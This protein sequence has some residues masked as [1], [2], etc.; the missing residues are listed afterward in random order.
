MH[1]GR[2]PQYID[3]NYGQVLVLWDKLFGTF[4]REVEKPDYGTIKP[5][6][7]NNPL[8]I[9]FAG[10]QWL[11]A[12]MASMDKLADRIACLWRPPE[13]YPDRQ[14]DDAAAPS[15]QGA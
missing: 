3:K 9:I 8:V 1:H 6:T 15:R 2:N 14:P 10:F 11:G 13:W 4:E 5:V 12:K 7:S